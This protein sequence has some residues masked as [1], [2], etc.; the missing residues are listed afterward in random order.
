MNYAAVWQHAMYAAIPL[1]SR[2]NKSAY[3]LV[4]IN[5]YIKIHGAT[6]KITIYTF[7]K[8]KC[9][10]AVQCSCVCNVHLHYTAF[11]I[12]FVMLNCI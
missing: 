10:K 9:T 6:I 11:L 2:T 4:I 12:M 8:Q 3:Q 7:G 5:I 1:F